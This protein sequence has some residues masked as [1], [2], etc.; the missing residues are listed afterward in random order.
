[1]SGHYHKAP[2]RVHGEAKTHNL[3]RCFSFFLKVLGFTVLDRV[4]D[5]QMHLCLLHS[6]QPSL[7]S[8]YF[9]SQWSDFQFPK[10]PSSSLSFMGSFLSLN[11]KYFNFRVNLWHF[12]F[13]AAQNLQM[14][15]G[16]KEDRFQ[17]LYFMDQVPCKFT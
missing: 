10:I 8:K 4:V 7:M 14:E 16:F 1:M 15:Q 6:L 13:N 11:L 5:I 17:K 3:I 12:N 2:T 9:C